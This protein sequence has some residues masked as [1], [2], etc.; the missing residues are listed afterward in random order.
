MSYY[1]DR[2]SLHLTYKSS[3]ND[4]NKVMKVL[5]MSLNEIHHVNHT[6]RYWNILVRPWVRLLVENFYHLNLVS[7][8]CNSILTEQV[9]FNVANDD[10][11]FMNQ[12][13]DNEWSCKFIFLISY[14]QNNNVKDVN[15]KTKKREKSPYTKKIFLLKVL[16]IF[17]SFVEFILPNRLLYTDI[18]SPLLLYKIISTLHLFPISR[19]P[20]RVFPV[21][22]V[23]LDIREE[24]YRIGQ[25]VTK[26]LI[27]DQLWKLV[28]TSIP[29][30][31][32]E[33]YPVLVE[34]YVN[35]NSKSVR[36]VL[37]GNIQV[38]DGFKMRVASAVENG[39]KLIVAQH[40]GGYGIVYHD[41]SE[42]HEI[43]IS[44]LYLSAFHSKK[45]NVIQVPAYFSSRKKKACDNK[46][47]V[48]V[49][50]VYP[51]FY[52]YMSGPIEEQMSQNIDDQIIFLKSLNAKVVLNTR[53]R[54]YPN[55][56]GFPV[57][58]KYELSGFGNFVDTKSDYDSLVS[59]ASLVILSY[60]GT[61]WLD[62]LM[63]NTPTV[64]FA[65]SAHWDV[66]PEVSIYLDQLREVGI[67]HDSPSS[68]ARHVNNI[69]HDIDMWWNQDSLQDCVRRFCQKFSNND[70]EWETKWVD[71]IRT[72]L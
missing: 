29:L 16:S 57:E 14:L 50:V 39:A 47:A 43:D 8:E 54:Q 35:K 37:S 52:K 11:E 1:N 40:G 67:L 53:V 19:A 55:S 45:Q 13:S 41:Y 3:F 24:L 21:M 36:I 17:Q 25:T 18:R 44:D 34:R 68:A 71:V 6:Q 4:I 2:A 32:L 69:Y 46:Y 70:K 10:K 60:M 33:N 61:T 28:C 26:G 72:I 12:I 9:K 38:G 49:N 62:A 15:L 42:F 59:R 23:S 20:M 48:L 63:N 7:R 30:S 31:Y 58:K 51:G 22:S 5:S 56:Y 66:R 64:V 65:R 27:D